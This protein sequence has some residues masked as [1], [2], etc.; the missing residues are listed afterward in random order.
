MQS[1]V[2]T[3]LENG[4]L[5]LQQLYQQIERRRGDDVGMAVNC[6]AQRRLE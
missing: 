4:S 2:C 5:Y 1:V 6:L 3:R